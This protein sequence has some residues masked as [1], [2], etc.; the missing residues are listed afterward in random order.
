M[1]NRVPYKYSVLRYVHDVATGEFV[2]VGIVVHSSETGYFGGKCRTTFSRVSEFFPDLDKKAFKGLMRAIKA[3]L[4]ILTESCRDCLD[5]SPRGEDL[6]TLLRSILPED[7][8]ALRWSP[9]GSGLSADL[10]ATLQRLYDRHVT[11]YDEA[12]VT[13]RR[14]DEDVWRSFS[15]ELQRR[16]ISSFF[17]EKIIAGHDDK[18]VF[19]SAWKNGVWHCVETLSLDL[20]AAD[21]IRSKAR[22]FLGQMISVSDTSDH[23]KLYT[24][25][26]EPSDPTLKPAY[27]NAKVILGKITS[28]FEQEIYSESDAAELVA[29]LAE[30]IAAHHTHN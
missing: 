18:V 15:R 24:V 23:V 17:Q 9:A 14:T 1:N 21:S 27:E 3:R 6:S 30:Q 16:H 2:N 4:D 5:V 22:E 28:A 10:A 13:A 25:L 8:S 11:R 26:G 20:A 29:K 7:D 19:K 12:N